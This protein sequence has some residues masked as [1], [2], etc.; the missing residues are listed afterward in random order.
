MLPN[1]VRRWIVGLHVVCAVIHIISGSFGLYVNAL[2][3]DTGVR[4]SYEDVSWYNQQQ[5]PH[6]LSVSLDQCE[7]REL[8]DG[9]IIL[10]E[11]TCSNGQWNGVG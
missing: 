6:N 4:L 7:A 1:D 10:F 3:D 5:K 2:R 9:G 8:P 11:R